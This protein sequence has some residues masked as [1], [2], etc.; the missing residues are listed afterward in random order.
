MFGYLG[1]AWCCFFDTLELC[2]NRHSGYGGYGEWARGSRIIQ[3]EENNLV[4][5]K[6]YI[7]ME[8]GEIVDHFPNESLNFVQ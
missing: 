3:L 2:Y 7:R 5:R 8:T 6:N 4:H 1:N